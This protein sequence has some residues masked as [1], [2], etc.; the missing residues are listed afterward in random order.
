VERLSLISGVQT[1]SFSQFGFGQGSNRVC[2]IA[3]EGYTP[4]P[5]ED[6]NVRLQ[7]V[8]P[9]YFRAQS[10]PIRRDE[11]SRRRTGIVLPKLPSSMKQRRAITF[12]V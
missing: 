11:S 5:D 4:D 12:M 3:P 2:C 6:K 8:S 7:P 9:G 1:A 10:I